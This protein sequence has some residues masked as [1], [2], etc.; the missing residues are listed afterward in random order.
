MKKTLLTL[1]S[2]GLV[3]TACQQKQ[4]TPA[5]PQDSGIEKQ[6]EDKLR[7]MTLEEKIGQMTQLVLELTA[8]CEADPNEPY[9]NRFTVDEEATRKL[10]KEYKIGSLLN[11][12][13]KQ[14]PT[15][16]QWQAI[17][18]P[19]QRISMEELGIPC[20]IGLDQNHG[21][22]Y[23]AGGTI[24]PQ[25]VNMGATFNRDLVRQAAEVT[26]YETRAGSVTWTF[27]PTIDLTRNSCWPRNWENFGEDP[28]VNAEMGTA[29]TLGFQGEDPNH[30]DQYHIAA[31][32]KHY[33]GY[34]A[35]VSGR[36]RTPAVISPGDLREKHFAPFLK[37]VREGHVLSVMVN[38]SSVNG[39]PVHASYEWLTKWLKEDLNWDGMIV[40][41]WADINNLWKR[42]MVAENRKE[43]I[44]LAINAG[45]DMSMDPYDSDFC[46]LL[47]EC[48]EEGLV[49][50][51][52]ID[53][54]AR[55]VLRMKYRLGLFDRPTEKAAEYK[56]FAAE[57]NS[58]MS[59]ESAIESMVLLKNQNGIL[60]L[61][62]GRKILLCGPNA[63]SMRTLH[64]GWTYTWQGS[65]AEKYEEPY[66]TIYEAFCQK[67]GIGNIILEEGVSYN[68]NGRYKDE[69]E[70]QIAKAVAAASLADI[71]VACIGENSY[72]ETPGNL[73]NLALSENQRNLVKALAKT[74]KPVILVLN[75][76][77]PR[78]IADIEPLA[79]G[80]VDIMLPGNYGGEALADLLAGDAN[81]SGR[82][83]FTYP[84]FPNALTT[85]DYK[86]AA[87]TATMEGAYDYGAVVDVQWAFGYGLSYTTFAYSNL[88]AS[89]EHFKAG[90]MLTFSV[91]VTNTGKRAGKEAVLL[92]SSDLVASDTPDVRRLRQFEKI[93]LEPGETRTVS[94]TI[95]ANDLAFADHNGQWVLENGAFRI[96]VGDQVVT[97]TCDE[98][99]RWE[100]P[101]I[102]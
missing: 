17:I 51:S 68:N 93:A 78:L 99:H 83:P 85:Y 90:D 18:E 67:F 26:A 101:N 59:K 42:E 5:I 65:K 94:L 19:I 43:A 69:K 1:L 53:D 57:A 7:Q 79:Q 29:A 91:D 21:S 8:R 38:S 52:R 76:G 47:K 63:N 27:N 86:V 16:E 84:R 35:P 34:G 39:M 96:Q 61:S 44:A 30:I 40:T 82:L 87:E 14:S 45:I 23:T 95:P 89:A 10:I 102:D 36:D 15:P 75:E 41:D 62:A 22:T 13:G 70:P 77:R 49:P 33:M 2:A 97:V 12:I 54:A 50:M 92:F 100:T 24:F 60:P 74:G 81:F 37:A 58:R 71:I 25:N 73:E 31:C 46:T 72:C 98:T 80:I 9:G 88:K 55:R 64:G 28:Y 4:A 56:D 32:L 48:V 11:Q 20:L 6:M 66:N 3:L